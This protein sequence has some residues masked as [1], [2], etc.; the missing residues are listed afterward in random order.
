MHITKSI[1]LI[2][3]AFTH[4]YRWL[5]VNK[6]AFSVV[7]FG[8]LSAQNLYV[9]GTFDFNQNS[10]SEII[11]LNSLGTSLDFIELNKDGSHNKIWTYKPQQD[12][13]SILDA[14]FSD[15]NGDDFPELVIIESNNFE[16]VSYTH[17]TLPTILLV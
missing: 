11:T 8:F 14:K 6:L 3:C 16:T 1:Y 9:F 10:R 13:G 15:L 12:R 7:L 4:I 17:L 2:L 5:G